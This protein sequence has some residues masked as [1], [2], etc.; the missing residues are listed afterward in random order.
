MFI[1]YAIPVGL[2]LGLVLG[3][4]VAGVT[5]IH[6]RWAPL[7]LAGLL[8]QVVLFDSNVSGLVGDAL[9]VV[10]LA[11]NALVL[12]A[13]LANVSIPGMWLVV[14]GAV[15]NLAAIVANGGYMPA[16]AAAIADRG[17]SLTDTHANTRAATDPV[18]AALIDRIPLPHWLPFTNVVSIGDALIA[19]GV[20]A[21]LAIAMYRARPRTD[22]A[23]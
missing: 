7:A 5:K 11:S 17:R 4:R 3:G 12:I 22:I 2:A 10:Y 14:A 13:V 16:S 15:A 8:A 9:P 20:V 6:F 23:P 18:F 21:I 19:A 1:L